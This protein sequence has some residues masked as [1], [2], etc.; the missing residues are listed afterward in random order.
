MDPFAKALKCIP[1][2]TPNVCTVR[3]ACA[4]SKPCKTHANTGLWRQ[5]RRPNS[6]RALRAKTEDAT[7]SDITAT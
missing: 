5:L 1:R 7:P 3:L 2:A 6:W 4:L